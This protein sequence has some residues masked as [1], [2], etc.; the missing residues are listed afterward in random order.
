MAE[1][2]GYD[3]ARGLLRRRGC[4]GGQICVRSSGL[5]GTV[6]FVSL[7]TN[8]PEGSGENSRHSITEAGIGNIL[9]RFGD[10][11]NMDRAST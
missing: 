10:G 11:W 8:D 2:S 9:S 4:N 1:A 5:L 6:G 3:R 7:D